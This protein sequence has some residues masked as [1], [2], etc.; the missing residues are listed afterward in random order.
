MQNLGPFCRREML[1]IDLSDDRLK[2]WEEEGEEDFLKKVKF[3]FNF[4]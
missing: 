2:I 1:E 4:V 3:M